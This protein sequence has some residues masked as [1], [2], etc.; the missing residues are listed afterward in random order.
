MALSRRLRYEILRRDNHACRYC[1]ASA[2]DAALTIDHV[3]PVALGGRDEP[4]NLV[5]A[6][7][8]C[9]A[10]KSASNPD[11]PLVADVRRDAERWAFAMKHVVEAHAATLDRLNAYL[12]DVDTVW[13]AWE[14]NATK[15]PLPRPLAWRGSAE[16]FMRNHVSIDEWEYAVRRAMEHRNLSQDAVWTYTCGVLWRRIRE[17][18]EAAT[19]VASHL[20]ADEH[21]MDD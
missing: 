11:D 19:Y 5:T 12:D 10:G 15:K 9:N 7:K 20:E 13:C 16:T 18:T 14:V 17:R 21:E 3:V 8:D 6:C 2:P 4:S 1:G